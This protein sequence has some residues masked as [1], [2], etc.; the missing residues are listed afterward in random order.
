M[1]DELRVA[2]SQMFG[3]EQPHDFQIRVADLLLNQRRS[4]ILQAPTGS[5][6]TWTALFPF[7]HAWQTGFVFP[8][9]CLYA[10][11]LRV[12]ATQ[13]KEDAE[14]V[15]KDWANGPKIALQTGEQQDDPTFESDLIFTTID[16]VLSSALSVPYSLGYRRANL[17]AGAVFSSFLVCDEL[18]LFPIDEQQAQGA[19][20]T[21]VEQLR[22]LGAAIPFLLMTAT[23]SEEMLTTLAGQ[24]NAQQVT[25]SADELAKIDSQQKTRRYQIVDAPLTGASVLLQHQRRSIVIC[26]QIQR[27]IDLFEELEQAV[28]DDPAHARRTQVALLHSRFI[29]EHRRKTEVA[30]RQAFG[31]PQP[32]EM[33]SDSRIIVAT[34]AIEVGLDITCERLHTELAPANAV[35]Q[36]AGRCARYKDEIGDVFI[37]RLPDDT[38]QPHLPYD[39]ARCAATWNAF[40]AP[41]FNGQSLSFADEQQIVTQVHNLADARLLKRIE[42]N[43][44][45]RR[46]DINLATF[47]GDKQ[48]RPALIRKVDSRTLLVHDDPQA[49]RNPYAWRGF[50][51]FHGTLRGWFQ[52]LQQSDGDLPDWWLKYPVEVPDVSEESRRRSTYSWETMTDVA[53]L[54]VSPI[55]V[56]HP[57]LVAYNQRLG[58]RLTPGTTRIDVAELRQEPPSREPL[59]PLLGNYNLESYAE[60]IQK[61]MRYYRESGLEQQILLAGE[62]LERDRRF[63]CTA[64]QLARGARLA[65]ALHD[66]GK[67][68]EEWQQ[69]SHAYQEAIGEEQSP[70][71]MIVHTHYKPGTYPLHKQREE[72]VSKQYKRP[73]HA[74]EGACAAW[75]VII[76][77]L[78]GNDR[79]SRAVF[80]AIA[81]H[82]APF[83]DG[84]EAFSLHTDSSSA[85]ADALIAA[86]LPGDLSQQ[87]SMKG[88]RRT[89]DGA[90]SDQLIES[91]DLGEWLLYVLI[92]RA[93]RLC[94]GHSLEGSE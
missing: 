4:V 27:A 14:R 35:I 94:D 16:Q 82:H 87:I 18:H 59:S 65:V 76:R 28:T 8:R 71:M 40:S 31:R 41:E 9:K 75:P 67:L 7:L 13:F 49:I 77:A 93:L 84:V 54:D 58:F 22:T 30:L 5:G 10:V 21:L 72:E 44:Y 64:A 51:L 3:I 92:V 17:N 6:K 69:W 45:K 89:N 56:V 70:I 37:Y 39:A 38:N 88:Q 90:L 29:Q 20:A 12:L 73:H 26:N 36:R 66:L 19:L 46:R 53:H 57:D 83:T 34:Q 91:E 61:M 52:R 1:N 86:G 23:L 80:T 81:R 42:S 55:F 43:S 15:T 25:V 74:A 47:Q 60:H 11:P 63:G 33:S 48:V 68:R 85:V 50:S 78:D 62:R 24:L 32:G 79:L 2:F